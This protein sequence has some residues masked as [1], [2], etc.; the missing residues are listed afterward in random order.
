MWVTVRGGV[1]LGSGIVPWLAR[2]ADL[3]LT[4]ALTLALANAMEPYC[5]EPHGHVPEQRCAEY[6]SG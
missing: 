4:L 5:V 1:G 3:T 6:G 2:H